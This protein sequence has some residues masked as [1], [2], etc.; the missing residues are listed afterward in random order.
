MRNQTGKWDSLGSVKPT[1]ILCGASLTPMKLYLG[2][3]EW[4][5]FKQD[6]LFSKLQYKFEKRKKTFIKPFSFK[7]TQSLF[8]IIKHL[9]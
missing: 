2:K 7:E 9:S 4:L 6:F 1:F 8:N 5:S 3:K